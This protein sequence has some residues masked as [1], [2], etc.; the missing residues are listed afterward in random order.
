M[1]QSR[2]ASKEQ[3]S[4]P[5]FWSGRVASVIAN[6]FVVTPAPCHPDHC[7]VLLFPTR[8]N[9]HRNIISSSH[10]LHSSQRLAW[11][12]I[13]VFVRRCRAHQLVQPKVSPSW[14][15]D[16]LCCAL[17]SKC[18]M[19]IGHNII[20]VI[21]VYRLVLWWNVDFFGWQLEA[22]EVFEQVGMVRL[23]EMEEGEGGVA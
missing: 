20:L 1:W 3:Q 14:L 21:G 12:G 8:A 19:L 13:L 17:N 6:L 2:V 9:F 15:L 23:V 7:T 4:Y 16:L 11:S 10:S 18:R 22:R 5:D